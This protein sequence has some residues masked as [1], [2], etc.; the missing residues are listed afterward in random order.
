M[1]TVSTL[2]LTT[3]NSVMK[4]KYHTRIHMYPV[5][6]KNESVR[7]YPMEAA[8]IKRRHRGPTHTHTHTYI[9]THQQQHTHIRTHAHT[10]NNTHHQIS[11]TYFAIIGN[12]CKVITVVINYFMWD[13]HASPKGLGFLAM[14]LVSSH[15]RARTRTHTRART[16]TNTCTRHVHSAC[17]HTTVVFS[18]IFPFYIYIYMFA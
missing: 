15:T 10:N 13:L 14:S 17:M 1:S 5:I 2:C 18:S 6:W 3:R 4:I 11:S 7:V 8:S 16:Y 12:V 9:C